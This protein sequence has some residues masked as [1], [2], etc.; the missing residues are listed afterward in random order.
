[1]SHRSYDTT[2]PHYFLSTYNSYYL[3]RTFIMH[4]HNAIHGLFLVLQLT[5]AASLTASDAS[6]PSQSQSKHVGL[7]LDLEASPGEIMPLEIRQNNDKCDRR[8][9]RCR[10]KR[11]QNPKDCTKCIRCP[12]GTKGDLTHKV[13]IPEKRD[14]ADK[15]RRFGEKKNK[16]KENYKKDKGK[17]WKNKMEVKQKQ[18]KEWQQNRLDKQKARKTRRIGRCL[19]LMAVAMGYT[20]GHVFFDDFFDEDYLESMD[21]LQLWPDDTKEPPEN[22]EGD[23][24][25]DD[26][27]FDNKDYIEEFLWWGDYRD[28][29]AKKGNPLKRNIFNVSSEVLNDAEELSSL[30]FEVS[31]LSVISPSSDVQVYRDEKRNPL[32]PLV[33]L[34]ISIVAAVVRT[35]TQATAKMSGQLSRIGN[36]VQSQLVKQSVK[37]AGKNGSKV[38]KTKQGEGA[39]RI[40]D[41]SPNIFKRC[42][43]GQKLGKAKGY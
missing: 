20:A 41:K 1:M 23:N 13:C 36:N 21:L 8:C 18:F 15:E 42:L 3:L 40:A 22:V 7:N 34:V 38:G 28:D 4:L 12:P 19:P 5:T 9:R 11:I 33:G 32:G 10:G 25:E 30:D 17:E 14:P 24:N 6:F 16:V 26:K 37:I 39:K 29:Q 31:S 27:I 35:A 2:I 43:T